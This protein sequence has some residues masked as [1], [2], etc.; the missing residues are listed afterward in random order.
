MFL[1]DLKKIRSGSFFLQQD[2]IREGGILMSL[3]ETFES[4]ASDY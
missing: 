1:E 2:N 3:E 4:K